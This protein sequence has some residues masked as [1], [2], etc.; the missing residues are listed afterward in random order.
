MKT[1]VSLP[2]DL[3]RRAEKLAARLG[4]ARSRLYAQALAE[5]LDAHADD[6]VTEAL[7]GVYAHEPSGIDTD[8]AAAQVQIIANEEW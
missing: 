7:N 5:Y 6:Q 4:I 8:L 1:A 2:D 3:F